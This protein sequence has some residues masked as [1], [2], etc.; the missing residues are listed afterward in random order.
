MNTSEQVCTSFTLIY[1]KVT[2]SMKFTAVV[3]S[4][5]N[6]VTSISAIFG[7]TLIIYIILKHRRLQNPSNLLL[8]SLGI[9]DLLVGLIEQPLTVAR[10]SMELHKTLICSIRKTCF[11]VGYFCAVASVLNIAL[12]SLDRCLAVLFPFEYET[13]VE[14]RKYCWVIAS[15]WTAWSIFNLL[16]ALNILPRRT[17]FY[18]SLMI[19]IISF[20][21]VIIS[22]TLIYRVVL[23]LRRQTTS[24][25]RSY[26]PDRRTKQQKH[27]QMAK[28]FGITIGVLLLCYIPKI[29]ILY[30][31][32]S[33][34]TRYTAEAWADML[35]FIN[36]SLNPIIYCYR[37]TEIREAMLRIFWRRTSNRKRTTELQDI[38]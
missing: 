14:N 11:Y 36:S 27:H 16:S 26:E 29:S 18:G 9:T 28:T 5:V 35:V 8:G 21:I 32:V 33:R 10:R 6:A 25:E 34:E 1:P 15:V 20:G 12:I 13:L 37:I 22:Y 24:V 23:K 7:N 19:I 30:I 31:K 2:F 38:T 3:T 17:F 4:I